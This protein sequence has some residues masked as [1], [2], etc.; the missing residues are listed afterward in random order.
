MIALHIE[1][2]EAL[3]RVA[4]GKR[5]VSEVQSKREVE[6]EELKKRVTNQEKAW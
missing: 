6:A 3:V 4:R 1:R 2:D 5:N